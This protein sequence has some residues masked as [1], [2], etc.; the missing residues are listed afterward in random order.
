MCRV[1]ILLI[2]IVILYCVE[3][4]YFGVYN[5]LISKFAYMENVFH[6]SFVK[7]F[8]FLKNLWILLILIQF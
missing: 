3:N 2:R 1:S 8:K 6:L 7:L 4:I 5:S